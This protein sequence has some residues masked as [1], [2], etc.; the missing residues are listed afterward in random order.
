VSTIHLEGNHISL[1]EMEL[2][3]SLGRDDAMLRNTI[4]P[5]LFE[6]IDTGSPGD[7]DFYNQYARHRGG[8]VLILL[9][10]VGRVAVP[11][12]RQGVPV[13]GVDA[14]HA[15]IE[16]AKRKARDT[17]ATRVM[18]A[19]ADP[20]DFVSDSRHPLVFI[21]AGALSRL[22]TLE[23]QRNA[24][25]AVRNALALGGR[26][27]LDMP[28][29]L[30]GLMEHPASKLVTTS[31]T[32][33]VITRQRQYD[34]ARQLMEETVGCEWLGVDRSVTRKE[35]GRMTKRYSTPGELELLLEMCG[36]APVFFGS[37][38]RHPLL[39]GAQRVIIEADRIN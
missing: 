6:L 18:F 9:C 4:T 23:E 7:I 5:E 25:L 31:E 10:G 14:D 36:F 13:I 35:Y 27:V 20:T 15:M 1:L 29:A 21:P 12:A 26:L 19:A 38:D 22:L 17:G 39:P 24:L 28:L 32:T 33:A 37:F 30:P 11:I 16:L 3:G 8:P 34:P 2:S